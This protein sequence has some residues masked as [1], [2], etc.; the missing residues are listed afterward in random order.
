[1]IAFLKNRWL[2][3]IVLLVF[4]ILKLPHL[5]YPFYWDESWPYA[6]GVIRMYE[7]GPSLMPGAIDGELSRGHP[8]MFHFLTS[9]WMKVFGTSHIAMHT[10]PLFIAILFLIAI[11]EA[12]LRLFDKQVAAAAL[13]LVAF[14]Q[15]YFVQSSFVLLEVL[16]AFLAFVSVYFYVTKRYL[17][18]AIALT[19]LYY[20]KESG[21]MVGLVLG[22]DAIIG[23]FGKQ[24]PAKEKLY[25]ILA[26]G[27][28]IIAIAL[29]F[30]LQKQ[31]SGWYVLPLYSNGLE[32]SWPA[33]YEKIR[34]ASKV[35]FRDD[36][37]KYF[38]ALL[39]LL[40]VIAAIKNRK[41]AMLSMFI[42]LPVVALLCSDSY[43][44]LLPNY[45]TVSLLPVVLLFV[46]YAMF[47]IT[48]YTNT[49]QKRFVLL[50]ICV[51]IVFFYYT[52][53]NMFFIDRYLLLAF[54]PV[55]FIATIYLTS[56]VRK[57]N[58]K[59]FVPV[60]II[61]LAIE[62]YG[63]KKEIGLSDAK[64]G[65]FDGLYVQQASMDFIEKNNWKNKYIS[66]Y[67]NLQ[68]LRLTDTTTGFINDNT[69]YKKV[70]WGIKPETE[71]VCLDN[72]E[73]NRAVDSS[74]SLK[75]DTNFKLVFRTQKGIAWAEVYL[76]KDR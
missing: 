53:I 10:F 43:H 30:V 61:V 67:E 38:F 5:S 65:A 16:L 8:L 27:T 42:A 60:L 73:N 13:L 62:A 32:E 45:L 63:Y 75:L 31:V 41:P 59:L 1:M 9:L 54:V 15:I 50:Q 36:L 20:T 23:L 66:V 12:G 51:V 55:L 68:M 52:A 4:T 58:P 76:K 35:C 49:L 21:M 14:Q 28:P 46:V 72:I 47:L 69:P 34:S 39:L 26:L 24:K 19:M 17:L 29:F 57:I 71:I 56:I 6:S 7:H 11:H 25:G 64:I 2:L 74:T 70:L 22:I 18:A 33:Y 44:W 37:R 48:G 40:S 3:I